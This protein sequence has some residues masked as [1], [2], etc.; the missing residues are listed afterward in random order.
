MKKIVILFLTVMSLQIFGVNY[1]VTGNNLTQK[2]VK[3][4]N[5]EI[6]KEIKRFFTEEYP[7]IM[8]N[9]FLKEE[10]EYKE[11]KKTSLSF[12]DKYLSKLE[13]KINEINYISDK[14][15]N[16]I[17][18]VKSIDFES[19]DVEK[20]LDEKNIHNKLIKEFILN[21]NEKELE[22]VFQMDEKEEEEI[23]MKKFLPSLMEVILEEMD[24]VKTYRTDET[25]FE[26][27]KINGKWEITSEN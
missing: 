19:L 4:N 26:L 8:K 13:Y 14:K 25:E 5:S 23:L 3:T 16:V 11:L 15:A 20:I 10:T 24:K 12:M 7:K 2:E 27:K 6:E 17:L 18:E 1:K 9:E 22:E 21:L